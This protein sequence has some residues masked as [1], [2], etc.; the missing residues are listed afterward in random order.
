MKKEEKVSKLFYSISEVAEMFDVEQSLIRHWEQYFSAFIQ[1]VR[2]Q[3][4]RRCYRNEDIEQIRLIY[5]LTK[6]E[7]MTLAGAKDR[8]KVNRKGLVPQKELFDTLTY[9]K[10]ELQELRDSLQLP[11]QHQNL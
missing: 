3:S 1:P 11:S 4:K 9:L 6:E 10:K 2:T 7:G 5:H 8:L